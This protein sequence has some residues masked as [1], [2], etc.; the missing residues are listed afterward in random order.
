MTTMTKRIVARLAP[1]GLGLLFALG[2][3]KTGGSTETPDPAPRKTPNRTKDPNAATPGRVW[4]TP[5][6]PSAPKPV[7]FPTIEN[8]RLDNDLAVYIIENHEVPVVSSQL[9][10]RCGVM[11]HEYLASFTAQMLGE[12]TRSRSK[13]KLD[14]AIEFVGGTLGANSGMHVSTVFS[15]SL[16]NDLKLS[17]LLMADQVQNPVFPTTALDKL[18]QGAK[19]A[20]RVNSSRPDM[21]ADTLFGMVVYPEGHPY[22]RPLPTDY[23]IDAISIDDVRQFHQTFFRANNAFLLLSG[24]ITAAEARPLVER[25]FGSWSTAELRDLPPN[26]LNRFTHYELPQELVVHL[27]DRADSA[28]ASIRVG[29]LALARNHEDWAALEVANGILGS[30]PSSRLFGDLREERG[31]TYRIGS[32][33]DNGQAPGVFTISTQTRTP[34]TGAM[35]AGIFEHIRRM[36]EKEPP[37]AEFETV[38]RQVVGS[39]PLQVETPQQI[40]SKVREQIIF[41]LPANHWQNYRDDLT[42]VDLTDVR[43]AALRYIHALPVVVIVGDAREIRPQ[44]ERVLPTAK[45]FE[46]DDRLR[47]R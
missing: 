21:L 1:L 43:K 20:L 40:V 31:L 22:G 23:A 29:N 13:A 45:I 15:R 9:V 35:L 6:P 30:G 28:Q 33:V 18:K 14:E 4:P 44:L 34:T 41:G 7:R 37:R 24:D 47:R 8:F 25:A 39:F 38:V 42:R 19:A 3:C 11:D 17:L 10:V 16:R 32:S 5:P 36:R 27:V 26:P 46:Y 2:A 12:G